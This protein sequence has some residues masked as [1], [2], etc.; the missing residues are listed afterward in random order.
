MASH[1]FV[2]PRRSIG[3]RI[4]DAYYAWLVQVGNRLVDVVERD[5]RTRGIR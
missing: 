2:R 5:L 3:S 1:V 4:S